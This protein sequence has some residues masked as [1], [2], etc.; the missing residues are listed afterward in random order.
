MNRNTRLRFLHFARPIELDSLTQPTRNSEPDS[1]KL[2]ML[3]RNI[4][5]YSNLLIISSINFVRTRVFNFHAWRH[6]PSQSTCLQF[7]YF[8]ISSLYAN[9]KTELLSLQAYCRLISCYTHDRCIIWPS[10]LR[11]LFEVFSYLQFTNT[12]RIIP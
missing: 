11:L 4:Y 6:H 12:N 7:V 3:I 1:H 8:S 10:R 2:S 9:F 5:L